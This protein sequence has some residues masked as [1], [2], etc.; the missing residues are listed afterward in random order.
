MEFYG[1]HENEVPITQMC[2]L[3]GQGRLVTLT[4]DNTL[5]LWEIS[6][7]SG[8]Q[9]VEK[10]STAM[11]GRLKKVSVLCLD[12]ASKRKILLGTEGGNIYQLNLDK[13]A[14]AEGNIIYQ[15][16][17][18]KGAPDDFKVN[19]GAVE[20]LLVQP[21]EPGRLLIGYTRGLIVLWDVASQVALQT[22][23]ATQQ[24][25]SLSWRNDGSQFISAH[26]DGSFVIWS[27]QGSCSEPLE[28]PTYH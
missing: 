16:L 8:G 22:Y 12:T 20:A 25:E 15:D 1:Q 23:V 11:E 19:P 3:P 4:E 18:M 21:N 17:V 2:F 14:V 27:T 7:A 13:F 9:L 26:N 6:S 10:K 24:L 5:H 28:P